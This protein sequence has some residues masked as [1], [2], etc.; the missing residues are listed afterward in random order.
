VRRVA[1]L[2]AVLA[3]VPVAAAGTNPRDERE[4]PNP[5]DT[6]LA[7]HA[8]LQAGDLGPGW[9]HAPA[10]TAD[11]ETMRCPG[12]NPDFSAFTITGKAVKAFANPGGA[13][14]V[15]GVE[16]YATRAQAAGDFR[17]GARP[18]L[19]ACLRSSLQRE[20]KRRSLAA[21]VLSARMTAA[22]RVGQHSAAYRAVVSIRANG[23]TAR[24]FMDFLVLHRGR[25]L[26]SLL[27]SGAFKPVPGQLGLARRVVARMR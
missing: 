21:A 14:V 12:W 4:R 26:A 18:Q 3:A 7:T 17:T 19:A 9:V 20:F 16:V 27:F 11:D 2:L 6:A 23:T 1:I 15:S 25:T 24:V 22:P 13:S 10:S 5:A 8:T